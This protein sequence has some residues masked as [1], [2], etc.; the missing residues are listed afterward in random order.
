MKRKHW[1]ILLAIIFLLPAIKAQDDKFKALFMYNFTKYLEWPP[2][3][4]KSEFIIGVYGTSAIIS[5]LNII[6]QKRKVGTQQ[7]IVKR[8]T[9]PAQ[10]KKCNIVYVPENR[11]VK[12]NE[13][14]NACNGGGVVIVSD[15]EGLAKTHSGINYVKINGKQNF[16]ISKKNLEKQGIKVNSALLSL[17]IVVE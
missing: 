14:T 13:V 6:A 17:G 3:K 11:S 7:I 10:L 4:Q 16:E 1:L 12:I 5:E 8:I 9:D 15:K 2:E